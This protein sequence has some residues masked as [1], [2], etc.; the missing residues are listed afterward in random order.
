V[1]N[2]WQ[3]GGGMG[4]HGNGLALT[5][6]RE[7]WC[8]VANLTDLHT[9]T[10]MHTHT[11]QGQNANTHISRHKYSLRKSKGCVCRCVAYITLE[12]CVCLVVCVHVCYQNAEQG[13]CPL[14]A[15]P[16]GVHTLL[17]YFLLIGLSQRFP[18]RGNRNPGVLGL[19]IGGTWDSWYHKKHTRGYHRGPPGRAKFSWC[20]TVTKRGW[21]PLI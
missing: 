6:Q 15:C 8:S 7:S 5:V 3:A 2:R 13:A 11:S 20:C 12:V 19:S 18:T 1:L 16:S 4:C 17:L 21:E 10:R 9:N 14:S